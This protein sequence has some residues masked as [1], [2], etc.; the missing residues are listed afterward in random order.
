MNSYLENLSINPMYNPKEGIK[1]FLEI[2]WN[3][4]INRDRG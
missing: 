1:K 3:D 4:Y 2:Y